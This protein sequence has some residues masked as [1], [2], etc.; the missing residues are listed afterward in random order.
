MS[1]LAAAPSLR[2]VTV[3]TAGGAMAA[4][5]C[6]K[7][8]HAMMRALPVSLRQCIAPLL[9]RLR[10][11]TELVKEPSQ[12]LEPYMQVAITSQQRGDVPIA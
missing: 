6:R 7:Y 10:L 1:M 8:G 12:A 3:A 11:L 9:T 2:S 5:L 4:L